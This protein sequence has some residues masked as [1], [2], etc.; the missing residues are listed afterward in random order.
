[1][2]FLKGQKGSVGF[3]G[4]SDASCDHF[5]SEEDIQIA[6][7]DE[8]KRYLEFANL[9]KEKLRQDIPREVL[10]KS[11]TREV[12]RLA[13]LTPKEKELFSSEEETEKLLKNPLLEI[14]MSIKELGDLRA[15]CEQ[16]KRQ[17]ITK[18]K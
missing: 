14:V 13:D 2:E 8:Y 17:S 16:N 5:H 7:L 9:L 10:I 12:G 1:L 11:L 6:Y 3:S 15:R 4:E 18:A